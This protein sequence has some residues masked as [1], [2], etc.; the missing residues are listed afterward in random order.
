MQHLEIN[1]ARNPLGARRAAFQR[2][3]PAPWPWGATTGAARPNHRGAMTCPRP[4]AHGRER[5][6]MGANA[7]PKLAVAG[8]A[9]RSRLDLHVLTGRPR[10]WVLTG[11]PRPWGQTAGRCSGFSLHPRGLSDGTTSSVLHAAPAPELQAPPGCRRRRHTRA[12]SSPRCSHP[13]PSSCI[14]TVGYRGSGGPVPQAS[15]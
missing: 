3:S 11:R 5:E 7:V 10:P 12:A 2:D 14:T 8:E 15:E 1:N 6:R 9:T 13:P 4:A